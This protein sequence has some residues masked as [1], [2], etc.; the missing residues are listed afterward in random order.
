MIYGIHIITLSLNNPK[1]IFLNRRIPYQI[2][3]QTHQVKH[4]PQLLSDQKDTDHDS[5]DDANTLGA[6][7]ADKFECQA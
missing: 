6:I 4:Q 1:L 7:V 3:H 5:R 2:A